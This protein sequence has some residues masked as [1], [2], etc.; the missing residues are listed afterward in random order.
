[1]THRMT[2]AIRPSTS[3]GKNMVANLRV[4]PCSAGTSREF[5]PLLPEP[6]GSLRCHPKIRGARRNGCVSGTQ[7]AG[8]GC[9]SPYTRAMLPLSARQARTS[10]AVLRRKFMQV[11]IEY[12]VPCGYLPRA[13]QMAEDIKKKYGAD[14]ELVKGD[15]G[16]Y[17][18][19]VDGK[20]V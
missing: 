7:G 6:D 15:K 4:G 12:C 11:K 9:G 19:Y 10:P 17:D 3:N 14:V 1:M 20:L 18:V 16:I 8:P 13:T 5:S 2:A